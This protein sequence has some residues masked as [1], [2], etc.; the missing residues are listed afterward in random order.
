MYSHRQIVAVLIR[1]QQALSLIITTI[2]KRH[3]VPP[4]INK[5]HLLPKKQPDVKISINIRQNITRQ[6]LTSANITR[7]HENQALPRVPLRHY[8]Y[9]IQHHSTSARHAVCLVS[10]TECAPYLRPGDLS[11]PIQACRSRS[12]LVCSFRGVLRPAEAT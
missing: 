1:Q 10:G 12:S 5:H 11:E 3:Q 7:N 9:P 2:A 6:H 8:Q 4:N